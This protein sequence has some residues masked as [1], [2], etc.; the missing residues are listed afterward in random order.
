M[1]T[2]EKI[3]LAPGLPGTHTHYTLHARSYQPTSTNIK[4]I[5]SACWPPRQTKQFLWHK[6]T[7]GHKK[8]TRSINCQKKRI[9]EYLKTG[10]AMHSFKERTVTRQTWQKRF[11]N[12]LNEWWWITVNT[13]FV[14]ATNP[15]RA[16]ISTPRYYCRNQIILDTIV[17][18]K[19]RLKWP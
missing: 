9:P 10:K 1:A 4:S 16:A 18:T 17:L 13:F 5:G 11:W 8:N 12:E 15:R 6:R 7:V 3:A 19:Y 14:R 2:L